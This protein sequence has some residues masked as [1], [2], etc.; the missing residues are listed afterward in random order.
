MIVLPALAE[1]VFLYPEAKLPLFALYVT[2][3]AAA[4]A[5]LSAAALFFFV[6]DADVP[7]VDADVS[8]VL[9]FPASDDNSLLFPEEPEVPAPSEDVAASVVLPEEAVPVSDAIAG[10][11]GIIEIMSA[12]DNAHKRRFAQR[13]FCRFCIMATITPLLFS[14]FNTI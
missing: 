2:V 10:V 13:F 6:F 4:D 5:L 8:D 9:S 7:D 12:S 11:T 3:T 1:T 14:L